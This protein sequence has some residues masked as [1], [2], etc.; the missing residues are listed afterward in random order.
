MSVET[1][2]RWGELI[3]LWLWSQRGDGAQA[4]LAKALAKT[5][6]GVP[7]A[8]LGA[9]VE[10]A[11]GALL[12]DKLVERKAGARGAAGKGAGA[13]T[14]PGQGATA[15]SASSKTVLKLALT[16]AGNE[17]ALAVQGLER[18]PRKCDFATAQARWLSLAA[19]GLPHEQLPKQKGFLAALLRGRLG[20][21]IKPGASLGAVRDALAWR[22]L[23]VETDKPFSAAAVTAH[24]L[25]KRLGAAR[26]LAADKALA[27]LAAKEVGAPSPTPA[28]IKQAALL[29]VLEGSGPAPAPRRDE[30]PSSPS[31]TEP[32]SPSNTEPS[33][34]PNTGPSSPSNTGPSVEE[35]AAFAARVLAAAATCDEGKFDEHHVFIARLWDHLAARGEAGGLDLDGF[36]ARLVRVNQ[37]RLLTLSRADFVEAMSPEDVRRSEVRYHS[38]TFH[39]VRR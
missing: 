39:F 16:D 3:L 1:S 15:E 9:H 2:G 37:A 11:I 38:A 24:L 29:R 20:L 7:A 10:A 35:D 18:V 22:E 33:S 4:A 25:S 23:G 31:N 5:A 21:P 30:G 34:P 14:P 28:Q 36:K 8:E 26:P 27:V 13:R 32:S 17:R 6:R 12:R 19:L